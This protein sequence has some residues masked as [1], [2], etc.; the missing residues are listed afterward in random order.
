MK[1]YTSLES[2]LFEWSD[3]RNEFTD[4]GVWTKLIGFLSTEASLKLKK[5][6]LF[7]LA[8]LLHKIQDNFIFLLSKRFFYLIGWSFFIENI[9]NFIFLLLMI[10]YL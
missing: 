10:Y 6:I 9:S 8:K 4:L 7:N 1:W 3:K 5:I 2:V